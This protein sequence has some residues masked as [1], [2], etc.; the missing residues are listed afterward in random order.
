MNSWRP[1]YIYCFI[2]GLFGKRMVCD[3]VRKRL[4]PSVGISIFIAMLW[5]K[6]NTYGPMFADNHLVSCTNVCLLQID[7]GIVDILVPYWIK[8]TDEGKFQFLFLI[9]LGPWHPVT[10][11]VTYKVNVF[12]FHAQF[13]L[14]V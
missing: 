3:W 10:C 1:S 7:P 9:C 8:I 6:R 12:D 5:E 14:I 11:I 13:L 4:T 2:S